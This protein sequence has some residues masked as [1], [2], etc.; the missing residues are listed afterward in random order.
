MTRMED[1]KQIDEI[2]QVMSSKY[3]VPLHTQPIFSKIITIEKTQSSSV[4]RCEASPVTDVKVA[5]DSAA[6]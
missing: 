4:K 6:S 5:S 2:M 1:K 3:P